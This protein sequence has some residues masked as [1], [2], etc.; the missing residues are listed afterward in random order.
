LSYWKPPSYWS[1]V[2]PQ[3]P[4]SY[5]IYKDDLGYVCAKN[6]ETGKIDYR[7]TDAATVIQAAIDALSEGGK[8][9]LKQGIYNISSD[10]DF[11][12]SNLTIEGESFGSVILKKIGD[13]S[14]ANI[15]KGVEKV[16][17]RNLVI[18]ASQS[19]RPAGAAEL[20]L[21]SSSDCVLENIYVKDFPSY[22]IGIG[23]GSTNYRNVLR[24][25]YL[26]STRNSSDALGG[27]N[28]FGGILDHIFVLN[29][30]FDGIGLSNCQK[31]ILTNFVTMNC[32]RGGVVL[33]GWKECTISNG[34]VY[35]CVEDSTWTDFYRAG[36][37]MYQPHTPSTRNNVVANIVSIENTYG[38][39]FTFRV[40]DY[41]NVL[42]NL[43]AYRNGLY[44]IM[45]V[46]K[47]VMGFNL[48]VA[49][50]NQRAD[51]P[52]A[53]LF[54]EAGSSKDVIYGI[55][56]YDNQDTKTQDYCVRIAGTSGS[57]TS[58]IILNG[59]A[60]LS[61]KTAPISISSYASNIKIKNIFGY[62]T[63]NSGTATFSGDGSTTDFE[64]GA[65]GLAVTDPEKIV[66]KVTP[67][68]QDAI[69]A[70][71]CV[72]YVDPA[73]NTKIRVKFASAPASGTDNVKI[74]WKAEVC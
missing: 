20:V 68:S 64:I 6:G 57:P 44:G 74:K 43:S 50:N 73:D 33:D 17:I 70:S 7:D 66:V 56:A 60:F 8:I 51:T 52:R 25:I 55:Y 63:E 12:V 22:G 32:Q 48:L 19:A 18:D 59:G 1:K 72:G 40:D 2:S 41:G 36:F 67:I 16:V 14:F 35:K 26:D 30:G 37:M 54:I 28:M 69:N 23:A 11:S 45:L 71:P 61:Y 21:G 5:I 49:E 47:P 58:D 27:G 9:L 24:N 42:I 38:S 13:V 65:H 53:G 3:Q 34:I 15:S 4:A 10:I 29:S 39:G 62:V 31:T 46:G